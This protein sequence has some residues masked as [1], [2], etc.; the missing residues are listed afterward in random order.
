M[1]IYGVNTNTQSDPQK[2]FSLLA[3]EH[4]RGLLTY[5]RALCGS[6]IGAADLVQDA[7][8]VAWRKHD[9][10]DTSRDFGAWLRGIVHNKWRE[11]LRRAGREV[12]VDEATLE[13]WESR[14][15]GW[16]E[17]R[18]AGNTELF[19]ALEACLER[20]PES[21]AEAVNRFY[22]QD[23]SGETAA[24][25]LDINITTFRKRL[26]RARAALRDCLNRKLPQHL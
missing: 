7:F 4:H 14:S 10:F 8:V 16:D 23:E 9:D 6:P 18:R 3:R 12:P 20:L 2:A 11:Q 1:P 15:S 13:L 17:N 22:Y 5:A 25:H 21:T 19:D 26:Q 24:S